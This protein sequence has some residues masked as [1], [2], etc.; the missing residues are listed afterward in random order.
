MIVPYAL[1]HLILRCAP[2]VGPVTMSALVTYESGAQP[3]AIGDNT[4]HRAFFPRNRGDAE[5][6]A[7]AL[8]RRG[9]S[10]DVGYAQIDS[11]NF[12]RFG[13]DAGDAFEPCLNIAAGSRILGEAYVRSEHR[14][15]AGQ[16]A[17]L[18]ALSAY[19]SG[20]FWA[21]LGYA[22]GVYATAASLRFAKSPQ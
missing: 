15:G 13:I 2:A 21:A 16:T 14:F 17:L 7:R 4:S 12:A 6:L 1:L 11:A 3:F 5:T 20:G 10:I 9:H 19:N 22:R 8:L 18:H